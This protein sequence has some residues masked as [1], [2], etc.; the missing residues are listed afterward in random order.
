MIGARSATG[1]YLFANRALADALGY[2][3]ER[4][5]NKHARDLLQDAV[6]D[7]DA[8]L[9]KDQRVITQGRAIN[10]SEEEFVTAKGQKLFLQTHIVPLQFYDELVAL[11]V[12]KI[13]RASCRDRG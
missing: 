7:L 9:L 1:H 13:G 12:S 8:V 10:V 4:M 11:S 2:T 6:V 5:R 3:P